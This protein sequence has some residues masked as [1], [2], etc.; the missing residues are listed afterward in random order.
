MTYTFATALNGFGD[1]C[2]YGY[3]PVPLAWPDGA[4]SSVF[5]TQLSTPGFT[6]GQAMAISASGTIIG[7]AY[8]GSKVHAFVWFKSGST[9]GGGND[10]GAPD[11]GNPS[12][13]Q[14]YAYAVTDEGRIVGKAK[15]TAGGPLHA[16]V[17]IPGTPSV[18]DSSYDMG[19]LGG[20][21]SQ[22]WD[23]NDAS[24]SVGGAQI[25]S[26]KMRAFYLQ[27]GAESLQ[28]FDELPS[29]P[30]VTRTDYQSEAYG[31]NTFGEVVGYAQ[32][33]SLA[34]RAFKYIPGGGGTMI[35]LNTLL[36]PGSP[37]VLT[38][39]QSMNDVGVIVGYGTY[40][41]RATAW[42]LY[43]QCQD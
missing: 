4:N 3:G 31:V 9:W 36:P 17:T 1:V 18:T 11:I 8:T 5:W 14:A 10:L 33:Q 15:F 16:F 32:N 38:K 27:V 7:Y 39:A 22:V 25:A 6:Y 2:G 41:G 34:S 12:Q 29:L 24:G 43:P 37:W 30:G 23:M 20:T 40:S 28:P 19:T 13:E 21:T 35:D 26:G 42:I